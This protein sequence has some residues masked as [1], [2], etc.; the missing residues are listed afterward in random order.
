MVLQCNEPLHEIVISNLSSVVP[1]MVKD[2]RA[3]DSPGLQQLRV[4]GGLRGEER[5]PEEGPVLAARVQHERRVPDPLHAGRAQH[6]VRIPDSN[7]ACAP[8]A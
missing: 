3:T 8:R 2:K 4:P 5:S 6:Q 7:E 1:N